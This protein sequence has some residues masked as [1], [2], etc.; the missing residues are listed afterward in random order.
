MPVATAIV[1]AASVGL[2]MASAVTPSVTLSVAAL[3]AFGPMPGI[4]KKLAEL[5]DF[6]RRGRPDYGR[7]HTEAWVD[8]CLM[9]WGYSID[10]RKGRLFVLAITS[11]RISPV[12]S[13]PGTKSDQQLIASPQ[14]RPTL[15]NSKGPCPELTGL[16]SA[17][18][19]NI[20]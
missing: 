7:H 13:V 10:F 19:S 4:V 16:S 18:A 1:R 9:T 17:D 12:L 14:E 20:W 15:E 8:D 5:L 2:P 11:Q 3:I 6:G